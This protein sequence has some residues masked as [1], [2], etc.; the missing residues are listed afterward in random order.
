MPSPLK[1]RIPTDDIHLTVYEWGVPQPNIAS[2]MFFHATGFHARCW[3]GVIRHLEDIH[4]FA[5]DA[6]GHGTS[7]KPPPP[8]T[9][10]QYGLDTIALVQELGLNGAIGVG[11]SMG[12]N[13]VTRAAAAV[14]G[15]FSALLLVDPVILPREQYDLEDYSIE[16]HFILNRRREWV[17]AT[18]MYNSFKGRGPFTNWHDDILH[19]YCSY[20]IVPDGDGFILACAPEVEAHIYSSSMLRPY[21]D[22]YEAVA[23]IDIPVR[24]MRCTREMANTT[25]DLSGS[26]TAPDLAAQFKKGVDIALPD[27]SHFIPMESPELVAQHVR[28]LIGATN[29]N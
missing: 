29:G 1:R 20:G 3:D 15:A 14:P 28:E 24:V 22:V 17:S 25:T 19:D 16:G 2:A 21:I 8:H 9:W 10:P 26:P 27:N 23:Q 4:C 13:A 6:R 12:G 7:D 18:E 5:V 11:H